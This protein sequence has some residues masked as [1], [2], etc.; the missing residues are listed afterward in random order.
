MSDTHQIGY[1]FIVL[2]IVTIVLAPHSKHPAERADGVK[3]GLIFLLFGF[4]YVIWG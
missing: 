3:L 1:V 2:G 4:V